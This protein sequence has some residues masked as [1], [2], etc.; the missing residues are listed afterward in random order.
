MHPDQRRTISPYKPAEAIVLDSQPSSDGFQIFRRRFIQSDSLGVF[1]HAATRDAATVFHTHHTLPGIKLR[2]ML[3][4]I[5]P[6]T[7]RVQAELGGNLRRGSVLRTQPLDGR[8]V[9]GRR[10]FLVLFGLRKP[11][12]AF[13]LVLDS[14]MREDQ[15]RIPCTQMIA[16][17]AERNTCRTNDLLLCHGGSLIQPNGLPVFLHLLGR[18]FVSVAITCKRPSPTL[19]FGPLTLIGTK[20]DQI[21]MVKEKMFVQSGKRYAAF[22]RNLSD[23]LIRGPKHFHRRGISFRA[24]RTNAPRLII[25]H[26]Q[27]TAHLFPAFEN[28]RIMGVQLIGQSRRIEV[29]QTGDPGNI[30]F[31][32]SHVVAGPYRIL[33]FGMGCRCLTAPVPQFYGGRSGFNSMT[34]Q[35]QLPVVLAQISPETAVFRMCQRA[36]PFH[37][38]RRRTIQRQRFPIPLL[39]CRQRSAATLRW[40]FVRYHGSCIG[41]PQ[42]RKIPK[43]RNRQ[44]GELGMQPFEVHRFP[45]VQVTAACRMEILPSERKMVGIRLADTDVA[46]KKRYQML[47]GDAGR[48]LHQGITTFSPGAD[49]ISA[50]H[51]ASDRSTKKR[52]ATSLGGKKR[53]IRSRLRFTVPNIPLRRTEGQQNFYSHDNFRRQHRCYNQR[54]SSKPSNAPILPMSQNGRQNTAAIRAQPK[55]GNTIARQTVF[56]NAPEQ[57]LRLRANISTD[58][59]DINFHRPKQ[60][61]PQGSNQP[62]PLYPIVKFSH[63]RTE[64]RNE[65]QDTDHG[66]HG[67]EEP[68]EKTHP[69][70]ETSPFMAVHHRPTLI[71]SLRYGQIL[72]VPQEKESHRITRC[73]YDSRKKEHDRTSGD[74]G[75]EQD[76]SRQNPE[77]IPNGPERGEQIANPN[78]TAATDLQERPLTT[79][80]QHGQT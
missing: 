25:A 6:E 8:S 34:S 55:H 64:I 27:T 13:F 16:K 29:E 72:P 14:P 42:G 35:Y 31:D 2:L 18:R 44:T 58:I 30:E 22:V 15:L 11:K 38:K 68:A 79:G 62:A 50:L 3:F 56:R 10:G 17:T 43:C 49:D 59:I 61:F 9:F 51:Q 54:F 28:V 74:N 63:R 36:N 20:T 48:V 71:H 37:R 52:F 70:A 75:E 65:P 40:N 57:R 73:Q 41:L 39:S 12:T 66:N 77:I 23:S 80:R 60:H 33:I 67:K 19:R 53:Q 78:D 46:V 7:L 1:L 32:I 26:A 69:E 47:Q 5:L 45:T 24:P 76:G 4:Q 21:L